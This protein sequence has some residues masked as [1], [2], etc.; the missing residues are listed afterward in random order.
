MVGMMTMMLKRG[1]VYQ[2]S[3]G[4]STNRERGLKKD[5]TI[6]GKTWLAWVEVFWWWFMFMGGSTGDVGLKWRED[7]FIRQPSWRLG[8][9]SFIQNRPVSLQVQLNWP[10]IAHQTR[11]PVLSSRF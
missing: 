5:A 9:G 1:H 4:S 11:C 7:H 6:R 8:M 3:I 2:F 10:C